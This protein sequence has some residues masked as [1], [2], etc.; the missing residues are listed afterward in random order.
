[1][2]DLISIVAGHNNLK[3]LEFIV[4]E[5]KQMQH[6]ECRL[7]KC[8]HKALSTVSFLES[9]THLALNCSPVLLFYQH[10]LFN[11]RLKVIFTSILRP[12]VH[13]YDPI[14]TVYLLLIAY[15]KFWR[16]PHCRFA[17]PRKLV[18]AKQYISS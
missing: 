9:Q 8:D 16:V 1:M 15:K 3:K 12:C 10:M 13:V 5:Y 6:I 14:N 7:R 4:F 17:W 11:N 2:F 18:P